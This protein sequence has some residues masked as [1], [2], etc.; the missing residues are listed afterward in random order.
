MLI[1][2]FFKLICLLGIV[3][4]LNDDIEMGFIFLNVFFFVN[5]GGGCIGGLK[6]FFLVEYILMIFDGDKDIIEVV[7]VIVDIFEIF[8]VIFVILGCVCFC[9]RVIFYNIDDRVL[10]MF[11]LFLFGL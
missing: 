5:F 8:V 3:R 9:R 2:V 6:L 10:L 1:L 11:G 7:F 4:L